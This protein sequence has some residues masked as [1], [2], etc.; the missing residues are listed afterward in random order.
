M[1][2]RRFLVLLTAALVIAAAGVLS[3]GRSLRQPGAIAQTR[4]ALQELRTAVDSCHT[5]VS[6]NQQ[7]LLTY[8][9][10]LDSVRARV[11]EL[12][13]LHPRGVPADSYASYM[14]E[15]SRYNDSVGIWDTRVT[16]LQTAREECAA[17]TAAHNEL[18]DS[19]RM[20]LLQQRE[21]QRR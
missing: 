2:R 10:Y 15:F 9:A 18:L 5:A 12:E 6:D 21:R 7:E 4:E 8:N 3:I 11:R 16:E 20:L 17:V 1:H 13:A 19:L 14:R